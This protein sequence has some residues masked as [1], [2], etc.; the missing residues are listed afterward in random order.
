[1]TRPAAQGV[2]IISGPFDCYYRKLEIHYLLGVMNDISNAKYGVVRPL[3][4]FSQR[5]SGSIL[6]APR[7]IIHVMFHNY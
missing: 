7:D 5:L 6:Q 3:P 4:I 2:S 1:M